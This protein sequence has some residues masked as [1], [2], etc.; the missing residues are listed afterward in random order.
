MRRRVIIKNKRKLQQR[1]MQNSNL[2]RR[3][4]SQNKGKHSG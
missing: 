1:R 4:E 3:L 2:K